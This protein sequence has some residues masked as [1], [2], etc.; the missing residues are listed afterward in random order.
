MVKY[1]FTEQPSVGQAVDP[2]KVAAIT[3]ADIPGAGASVVT[4]VVDG[5]FALG[6]SLIGGPL[7]ISGIVLL[8]KQQ[9]TLAGDTGDWAAMYLDGLAASA[10]W[11]NSDGDWEGLFSSGG[12]GGNDPM[13]YAKNLKILNLPVPSSSYDIKAEAAGTF[14]RS[15]IVVILNV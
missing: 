1:A 14:K 5:V 4:H 7:A 2:A 13:G 8:V 12:A 11:L 3:V 9:D 15:F 6:D 10:V